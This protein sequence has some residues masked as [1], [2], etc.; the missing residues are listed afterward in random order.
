MADFDVSILG[1]GSAL[2]TTRHLA[3][4]QIINLR[5][6][7]YMIDC[8]EGTQVQ[9]RRMR[10]KFSR[11][12]HIF[13]SHLHG[14]HCFGLPGLI[15]TFGMLGRTGDLFIHGPKEI[16]AYLQPLLNQFCKGISF[17]V[18]FNLINTYKHELVMEDRSLKVYSI[19]LNHRI[20]TCGYLFVEKQK[21]A[22]LI[23][24]MV[25]FYQIPVKQLRGIKQG[26]DYITPEGEV[27][28]N[29]RLTRPAT[30][31]KR[32][33]FCSDTAYSPEIIPIIKDIDLLYHEA[34]FLETEI[35]RARETYHSTAREAAEIAR[36]ANVKR[37]LIGHFSARYE[38]D[39]LML[40]EAKQLFPETLLANEGLVLSV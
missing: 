18:K 21:E 37:L 39:K 6:K 31:A 4:S 26:E 40:E 27:I 38:D 12:N 1:C 19:P 17:Q 5:D 24:E 7:L 13:I 10:I 23:K 30:P 36:L 15:S 11:L 32:Y 34:T 33:A 20:P 28:P 16:E 8:G 2:P 29:K 35:A 22:H 9:M 3:T 14:D 25:D